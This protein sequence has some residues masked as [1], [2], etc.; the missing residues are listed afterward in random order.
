MLALSLVKE[1]RLPDVSK[2]ILDAVKFGVASG[3]PEA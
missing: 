3:N 2:T 1:V